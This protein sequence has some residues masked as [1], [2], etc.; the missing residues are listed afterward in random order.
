MKNKTTL[1]D[2]CCT[3]EQFD[4]ID[5]LIQIL[6]GHAIEKRF[7]GKF[8]QRFVEKPKVFVICPI[9]KENGRYVFFGNFEDVSHVFNICTDDPKVIARLRSAIMN[10]KGWKQYISNCK[11]IKS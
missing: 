10:N 9:S 11:K 5:H 2:A 3:A 1:G 6:K 8:R 7:F 4:S